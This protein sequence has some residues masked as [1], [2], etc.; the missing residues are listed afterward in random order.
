[1]SIQASA[2]SSLARNLNVVK[3]YFKKPLALVISVLSLL[4]LVLNYMYASKAI[5]PIAEGLSKYISNIL[6][7]DITISPPNLILL[8]LVAGICSACIFMIYLFSNNGSG[9]PSIFFTVLHSISVV[10]LIV[11]AIIAIIFNIF[12][13]LSLL[14]VE[15]V[16]KFLINNVDQLNNLDVEEISRKIEAYKTSGF[17]VLAI[18]IA[19]SVFFLVYVN[20]QTSFLKSCK[21]SCKEPSVHYKGASTFG[22]L[23]M[24]FALIQLVFVVVAYLTFNDAET[25]DQTSMTIDFSSFSSIMILATVCNGV[26]L[27]F[28]G[29]FAKN[30][31]PF[32]KENENYMP[33]TAATRSPEANPMPTYKATTRRANDA[34]KQSQP[35]LYGEEPNNDP[36]KKS[37]Y[38][39]EELQNDYPEP[40]YQQPPQG[41]MMDPFMGSDPF[42]GDPFGQDPFAQSP[43]GNPYAPMGNPYGQPPMDPNGGNSY[44][45][46]MM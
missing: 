38:I 46:G 43:M 33:S 17:I 3:M 25:A 13:L 15:T 19:L 28:E 22:N 18:S 44:N 21:R 12:L 32:A 1:M 37:A 8:F 42:A 45:N 7:V 16:V 35:Y 39:P 36:T 11:S 23:S 40:Q 30:W 10:E 41:G 2:G 34:I 29:S 24:V 5:D 6:K 4:S 26:C 9:N 20:S 31:E 14:S 27:F